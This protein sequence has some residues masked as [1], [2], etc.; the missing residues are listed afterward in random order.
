MSDKSKYIVHILHIYLNGL[1]AQWLFHIPR[2]PPN[3][4]CLGAVFRQFCRCRGCRSCSFGS[5]NCRLSAAKLPKISGIEKAH[6]IFIALY[7]HVRWFVSPH[8]TVSHESPC[9]FA[10]HF[11]C[12]FVSHIVHC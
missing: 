1:C 5:A 11:A 9:H 10:S 2:P 12:Q 6:K 4:R 7:L 3:N 8:V